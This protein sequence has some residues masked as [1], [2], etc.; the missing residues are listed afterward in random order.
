VYAGDTSPAARAVRRARDHR[1]NT[2]KIMK[3]AGRKRGRR[4]TTVPNNV[5]IAPVEDATVVAVAVS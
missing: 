4:G 3:R 2:I 1:R 5:L